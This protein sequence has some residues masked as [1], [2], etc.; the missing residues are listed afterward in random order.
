MKTYETIITII[1]DMTKTLQSQYA[2][3]AINLIGPL[4]EPAGWVF[5]KLEW[6]EDYDPQ[7]TL[8]SLYYVRPTDPN[9]ELGF[10]IYADGS[11]DL[12]MAYP[13]DS[14]EEDREADSSL[15]TL[16]IDLPEFLK[17]K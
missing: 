3:E 12:Y 6:D 2:E 8:L 5:R 11:V 4:V 10:T 15:D 14:D 13:D 7:D 17:S 1:T 9:S 16:P